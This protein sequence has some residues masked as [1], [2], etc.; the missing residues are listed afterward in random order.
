MLAVQRKSRFGVIELG[1]VDAL[2]AGRIVTALAILAE[3]IV[4]GILMAVQALTEFKAG[5]S[6][7]FLVACE[8]VVDDA[9]VAFLAEHGFVL[10][11]QCESGF[12][13][14]EPRSRFPA[15][16]DVAIK[17]VCKLPAVF[18]DVTRDALAAQAQEGAIQVFFKCRQPAAGLI[19]PGLMTC[20]AVELRVLSL[21]FVAGLA[22]IEILYALFPKDQFEI[23]A[24]VFDVADL[25]LLIIGPGVK[26]L[27]GL[28]ALGEEGVASQAFFGR[29]LLVEAVAFG[30]VVESLEKGMGPGKLSG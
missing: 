24:L 10:A 9:L 18:I 6:L 1:P 26:P 8:T 2:P 20:P 16:H 23:A 27:A 14:V 29:E 17:A 7:K 11:G 30:A 22:V 3:F 12:V 21:Q 5:E 15:V 13:V 4:M 19:I 25:A 28:D